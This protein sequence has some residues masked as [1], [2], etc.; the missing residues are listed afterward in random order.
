MAGELMGAFWQRLAI[1]HRR[2]YIAAFIICTLSAI[3]G[4]TTLPSALTKTHLLLIPFLGLVG[5]GAVWLLCTGDKL[6]SHLDKNPDEPNLNYIRKLYYA[7]I[8]I[9]ALLAVTLL[10]CVTLVSLL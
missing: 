8:I 10:L 6:Q 2:P 5:V 3:I 7:I 1:Q 9:S 4:L